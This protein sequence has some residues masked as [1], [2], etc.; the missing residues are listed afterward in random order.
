MLVFT[1]HA[2]IYVSCW[3]LILIINNN[4]MK[5]MK[6]R[7]QQKKLERKGV[8]VDGAGWW[9]ADLL[10]LR[11]MMAEHSREKLRRDCFQHRLH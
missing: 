8:D 10:P 2:G 4:Y 7:K 9:R 5:T 3:Y 1:A 11:H 6:M